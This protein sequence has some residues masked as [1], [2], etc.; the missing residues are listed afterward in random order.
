MPDNV[1]VIDL[2]L[3]PNT[4]EQ[5][6]AQGRREDCTIWRERMRRRRIEESAVLSSLYGS[7]THVEPM[8]VPVPDC[9]MSEQGLARSQTVLATKTVKVVKTVRRRVDFDAYI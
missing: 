4:P 5:S 1:I 7:K 9:S 3:S 2:T 6:R 8:S